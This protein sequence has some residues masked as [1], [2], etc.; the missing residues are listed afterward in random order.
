MPPNLLNKVAELTTNHFG[1]MQRLSTLV[2]SAKASGA[3]FVKVQARNVE[4][5]YSQ[6]ELSLE[7]K[8]PFGK[9]FRDYRNQLE[10]SKDNF[11]YLDDL[12][13]SLNIKWF[14]SALDKVSYEFLMTTN[15]YAIKLPSTIIACLFGDG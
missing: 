12:C 8:S 1:D 10:L 7:Y 6:K 14:A 13:R 2:R 3:D 5:F 15:C 9:T 4:T 11:K